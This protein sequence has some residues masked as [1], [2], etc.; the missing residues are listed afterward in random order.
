VIRLLVSAV[1]SLLATGALAQGEDDLLLVNG[2]EQVIVKLVASPPGLGFWRD[3]L[4][5]KPLIEG[6]ARRVKVAPFGG[7]CVQDLRVTFMN[8]NDEKEWKR[9]RVCGVRKL[10]LLQDSNTGRTYVTYE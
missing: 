2:M 10:G 5:S 6:E 9:V 7:Q 3:N 8:T 4:V 1:F